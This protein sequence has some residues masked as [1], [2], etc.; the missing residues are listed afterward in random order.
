M[1]FLSDTIKKKSLWKTVM[2]CKLN[3]K[4]IPYLILKTF[5]FTI[6]ARPILYY[7]NVF[8]LRSCRK[9]NKF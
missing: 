3:A 4:T 6:E 1:G 2:G 8:F 7:V 9:Y 5:V